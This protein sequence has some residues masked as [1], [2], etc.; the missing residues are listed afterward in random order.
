[1]ASKRNTIYSVHWKGGTTYAIIKYDELGEAGMY[2][3]T[4]SQCDCPAGQNQRDCRHKE[5]VFLFKEA[6][7]IMNPDAR[8]NYDKKE[9]IL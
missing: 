2:T 6:G 1:M 8:Y 9:W 7:Q 3:I 4:A 5:M